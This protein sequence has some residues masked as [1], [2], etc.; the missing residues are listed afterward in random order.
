MAQ[1]VE[2]CT[3]KPEDLSSVPGTHMMGGENHLLLTVLLPHVGTC[4]VQKYDIYICICVCMY[5]DVTWHDGPCLVTPS[6]CKVKAEGS[7]N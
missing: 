7:L 4:S 5:I 2:A 3:S 1:W 6:T